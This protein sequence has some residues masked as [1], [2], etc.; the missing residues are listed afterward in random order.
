M[1]AT[2]NIMISKEKQFSTSSE[3]LKFDADVIANIL[4]QMKSFRQI[5]YFF[6]CLIYRDKLQTQKKEKTNTQTLPSCFL[7]SVSPFLFSLSLCSI[8]LHTTQAEHR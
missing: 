7:L 6:L 1:D 2:V 5:R 4:E 3:K 8:N